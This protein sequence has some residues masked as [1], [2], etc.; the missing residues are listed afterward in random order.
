[1]L[2][3]LLENDAETGFLLSRDGVTLNLKNNSCQLVILIV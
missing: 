2:I 3:L 1:M